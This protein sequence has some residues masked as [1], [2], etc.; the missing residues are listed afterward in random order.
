MRITLNERIS[1][2]FLIM[3]LFLKLLCVTNDTNLD[4]IV[5]M[6]TRLGIPD[7]PNGVNET[8]GMCENHRNAYQTYKA[9]AYSLNKGTMITVAAN[10]VIKF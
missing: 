7:L 8:T 2:A 1:H 5:D 6:I 10:D 9:P 3:C 4:S